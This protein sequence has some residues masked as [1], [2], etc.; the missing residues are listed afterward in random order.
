MQRKR[1]GSSLNAQSHDA[2]TI[3][4]AAHHHRDAHRHRFS[5]SSFFFSPRH[6]FSVSLLPLIIRLSFHCLTGP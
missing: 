6:E 3:E 5:S 1:N 4:P 2:H